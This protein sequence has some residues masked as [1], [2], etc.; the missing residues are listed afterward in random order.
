MRSYRRFAA[1][2]L[3]VLMAASVIS[4]PTD[5]LGHVGEGVVIQPGTSERAEENGQSVPDA[6]LPAEEAP[7]QEPAQP[8]IPSTPEWTVPETLNPEVPT[9]SLSEIQALTGTAKKLTAQE[10]LLRTS[11]LLARRLTRLAESSQTMLAVCRTGG[12]VNVRNAAGT[13]G[14]IIGKIYNNSVATVVGKEY[15]NDGL[16]YQIESGSVKGYVKSEFFVTGHEALDLYDSI[17]N[18]YVTLSGTDQLRLYT[19]PSTD[20]MVLTVLKA[21][22][23]FYFDG[24]SGGW[25]RVRMDDTV[26]GYC[27]SLYVDVFADVNYAISLE[28]ERAQLE[29]SRQIVEEYMNRVRESEEQRSREESIS[30]SESIRVR[31]SIENSRASSIAQSRYE[32]IVASREEEDRL[33]REQES[34]EDESRALER[35][36]RES[37]EAEERERRERESREAEERELRERESREAESREQE[38]REAADKQRR[39]EE[40][41]AQESREAEERERRE[42]ESREQES[43][44]QE[45]RERD[46]QEQREQASREQER[47]EQ[48]SRRE[49]EEQSI[50]QSIQ[51]S[52]DASLEQSREAE[53]TAATTQ[54][55][56]QWEYTAP[57]YMPHLPAGTSDLRAAICIMACSYVGV[58]DYVWGGTSLVTG[59][60]CSGFV[61]QIFKQFNIYVPRT[62]AQQGN[63]GSRV[64][65]LAEA[66]PGDLIHYN[67]HIGIFLGFYQG[68]PLFVHAPH[69]GERVKVSH[70][71]YMPIVSIRNV[72]GD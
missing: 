19:E 56:V 4:L 38:S 3:A 61:Q 21:D 32:S 23:R 6:A 41:R 54:E 36:E 28:E 44:E 5:A 40:S 11:L 24:E 15:G 67:G 22:Q 13:F 1:L 35:Y 9:F 8:E 60:D 20:S 31:E 26:I 69:E 10:N 71:D 7:P 27:N 72:I 45:S 33:R 58:L 65:S 51:D 17:V 46:E 18:R 29:R 30:E 66:R 42:R 62:S 48:E 52:I 37:R 25:T 39:E 14:T 2:A 47:R 59:A 34:R 55:E 68:V 12:Y 43:R 64:G 50:Q 70:A 57:G 16:W 49:S 63:Y 53:R